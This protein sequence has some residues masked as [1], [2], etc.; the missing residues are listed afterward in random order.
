LLVRKGYEKEVASLVEITR[1]VAKARVEG[2]AWVLWSMA[3]RASL[4]VK[5]EASITKGIRYYM[6]ATAG[7][8]PFFG[9]LIL[10]DC[11][12]KAHKD[13]ISCWNFKDEGEVLN[14]PEFQDW[15]FRLVD[16]V[17]TVTRPS[18]K[19]ANVDEDTS[20]STSLG[21]FVAAASAVASS[22]RWLSMTLGQDYSKAQ[23]LLIAYIV[24]LVKIMLELFDITLRVQVALTVHW[25]E[26]QEAFE[27]YQ[28][29]PSCQSIH[30]S[31][32]SQK[33]SIA[34]NLGR[35]MRHLLEVD[36]YYTSGSSITCY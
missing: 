29:S 25:V 36:K 33:R 11:L 2:D 19:P 22:A 12:Q 30:E 15:M 10:R 26:L 9:Q 17:Q 27:A 32:R 6:Q 21:P 3:Q 18:A 31:I 4:P 13:I 34:D 8:L 5:I 1:G 35:E 20:A 28:R 7:S 16:D 23:R 24:D 14:S